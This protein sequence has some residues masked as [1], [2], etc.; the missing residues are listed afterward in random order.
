MT[1]GFDPAWKG[2]RV[3]VIGDATLYLGD[4]RDVLRAHPV[5]VDAIVSDPPYGV[6]AE[7]GS[8]ATRRTGNNPNAGKMAW[9]VAP[10]A[11]FLHELHGLAT[12][13]REQSEGAVGK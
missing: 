12:V 6:L 7:S 11:M 10:D 3:E 13:N 8:A 4:C 1:S 2:G 9:D 5:P